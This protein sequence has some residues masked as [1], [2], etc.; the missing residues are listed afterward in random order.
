M[1]NN[2]WEIY[3]HVWK[4]KAAFFS[5][6]RGG[7]RRAV[8]EKYPVK[9]EFKNEVCSPPPE[10]LETRAKSGA[11]CALTGEW[12]GKSKG[13]IDHIKGNAS[14]NDWND[15][16][17]FIQHLCAT[18][19][20]LQFVDKEAH[21][22]KSYAERQG[23]SFEEAIIRKKVIAMGKKPSAE[24]KAELQSL[25]IELGTKDKMLSCYEKYLK[26]NQ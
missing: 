12:V 22:I 2:L 3:P 11:Y 9:L 20:N 24:M 16:L 5:W 19:D 17:P 25:G 6:L 1:Q 18:K 8:W 4:T 14:L 13:E 21:K 26:E 23:I 10:G 15:V 7:L